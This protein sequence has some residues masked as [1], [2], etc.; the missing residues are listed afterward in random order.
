MDPQTNSGAEDDGREVGW[1]GSGVQGAGE[2]KEGERW[3]GLRTLFIS[4]THTCRDG[5]MPQKWELQILTP[6]E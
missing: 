2:K 4:C 6:F 1:A 5:M 3:D